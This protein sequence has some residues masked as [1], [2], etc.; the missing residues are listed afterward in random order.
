VRG[1]WQDG[2]AQLVR[3]ADGRLAVAWRTATGASGARTVRLAMLGPGEVAWAPAPPPLEG[4]AH[5]L[6]LAAG[7]DGL[8]AAWSDGG[9]RHARLGPD[10]RWTA[11]ESLRPPGR[12]VSVDIIGGPS[13]QR[14]PTTGA[15]P[16]LAVS[17]DGAVLVAWWDD[18]RTLDRSG[19]ANH[20]LVARLW[21]PAKRAW[22]AP[23]YLKGARSEETEA[24]AA[25]GRD[26]FLLVWS[27]E[28]R[29]LRSLHRP[30]AGRG[31]SASAEVPDR[32]NARAFEPA[33]AADSD[34]RALLTW[35]SF[36]PGAPSQ[37]G[38][39]LHDGGG[40]FAGLPTP[41]ATDADLFQIGGLLTEEGRPVL[42]FDDGEVQQGCAGVAITEMTR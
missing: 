26:G 1:Y 23:E 12:T 41:P 16:V 22:S 33:L 35:R 9:I 15:A 11:A 4:D 28:Q 2:P 8:H 31:W 40:R 29:R 14:V 32:G 42:F 13:P 17:S 39:A 37:V 19:A 36:R 7:P 18:E 34:G 6:V 20:D 3:L 24:A 5:G 30:Y 10:G 38:A 21:D 27:N 25:A